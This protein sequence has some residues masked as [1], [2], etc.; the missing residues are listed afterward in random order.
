MTLNNNHS[1]TLLQ[2]SILIRYYSDD[3]LSLFILTA[4]HEEQATIANVQTVGGA[5]LA[6]DPNIQYQLRADTG[7]GK[8]YIELLR[9]YISPGS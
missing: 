8:P 1:L 3:V 7:Q 2:I 5:A 9:C 4:E 6:L